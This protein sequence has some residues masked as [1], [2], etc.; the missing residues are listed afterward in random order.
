MSVFAKKIIADA[1][2]GKSSILAVATEQ[3]TI[4]II[5]AAKRSED[6]PGTLYQYLY[7]LMN[8]NVPGVISLE[9]ARTTL[10]IHNNGVF[11]IKWSPT[12]DYLV[13]C[14]GDRTARIIDPRAS[15]PEALHILQGHTSTVKC[16]AWNLTHRDLLATGGRD[17]CIH[18]WDLRAGSSKM[19]VE[20][21]GAQREEGPSRLSPVVTIPYTHEAAAGK[22]TRVRRGV[23]AV[24]KS[25][26]SI[27]F[28]GEYDV[29]SS[30][31]ND[32]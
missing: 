18:L 10:Q 7:C 24:A 30:G 21:A 22:P 6:Y 5:N 14:S 16:A 13:S 29:V 8:V 25:V 1:K 19:E 17:G 11:D 20:E 26:T 28:T 3:G 23:T 12:D 2:G 31:S 15:V 4:E 9:P 32:G 27:V